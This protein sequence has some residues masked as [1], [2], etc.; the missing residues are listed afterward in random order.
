[1]SE[2]KKWTED[3]VRYLRENYPTMDTK[4]L[5][6]KLNRSWSSITKEAQRLG[7]RKAKETLSKI[8]VVSAQAYDIAL[9]NIERIKNEAP[10]KDLYYI[11]GFFDAEGSL[12]VGKRKKLKLGLQA[13]I[14]NNDRRILEW[15][16]STIKLGKVYP[17]YER[18][19]KCW[20]YRLS[21]W[22]A[23]AFI[24]SVL[25]YLKIK[26]EETLIK[27]SRWINQYEEVIKN[28]SLVAFVQGSGVEGKL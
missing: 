9:K 11:A 4:E 20:T 8:R 7:L 26:H 6:I 17:P 5:M 18:G 14:S 22:Q 13:I 10:L 19:S 3:E 23:Y 16:K 2:K 24:V 1:M 25:P 12:T 28:Q 27:L 21:G 15:I